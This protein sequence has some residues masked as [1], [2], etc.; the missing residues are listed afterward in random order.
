MFSLIK[1]KKN[2]SR[3]KIKL[4]TSVCN[5]GN[6]KRLYKSDIIVNIAS[7]LKNIVK[8]YT[9]RMF[10][11]SNL[12]ELKLRDDNRYNLIVNYIKPYQETFYRNY[13]KKL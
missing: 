12:T 8:D 9:N 3:D 5:N 6:I 2:I 11:M 13:L 4:I 1:K 7:F 10:V